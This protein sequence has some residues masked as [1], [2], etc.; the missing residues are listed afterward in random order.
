MLSSAMQCVC[1]HLY[2]LW[3]NLIGYWLTHVQLINCQMLSLPKTILFVLAEVVTNR[4]C[5][6]LSPVAT[7]H[8]TSGF[9]LLLNLYSL[10]I[11]TRFL[12]FL[13]TCSKSVYL[14][15]VSFYL[16][17]YVVAYLLCILRFQ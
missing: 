3:T 10:L 1:R 5:S 6:Q 14:T 7:G 12:P 8:E 13:K 11:N 15:S 16:S 2:T 17:V 9:V 4:V